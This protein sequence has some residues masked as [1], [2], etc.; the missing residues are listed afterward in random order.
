MGGGGPV[1]LTIDGE[2]VAIL[3][4]H[5]RVDR[6]V[7]VDHVLRMAA[8]LQASS[9]VYALHI[10]ERYGHSLP[11]NRDDRNRQIVEWFSKVP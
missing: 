7:P 5:S 9:K 4:L 6:L 10:Y 11:L 1:T 8:A 2:M 3:I